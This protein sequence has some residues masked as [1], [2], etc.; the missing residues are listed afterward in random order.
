MISFPP[1]K[2]SQAPN[3]AKTAGR[4]LSMGFCVGIFESVDF[5]LSCRRIPLPELAGASVA[6]DGVEGHTT[7][8]RCW[9]EGG[10]LGLG[11]AAS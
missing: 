8:S 6:G 7:I 11:G 9:S 1:M 4:R 3:R 5:V 2:M 10:V